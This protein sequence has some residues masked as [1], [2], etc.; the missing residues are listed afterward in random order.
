MRVLAIAI[1]GLALLSMSPVRAAPNEARG[2]ETLSVHAGTITEW[3]SAQRKKRQHR[4]TTGVDAYGASTQIAC[5][6][7]GCQR[8]PPGCVRDAE[9]S[10]DGTPTGF[11]VIFCPPR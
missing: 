6:R 5:P 1:A 11:D 10:W 2:V 3:S 4:A 7:A 9:R 8:V